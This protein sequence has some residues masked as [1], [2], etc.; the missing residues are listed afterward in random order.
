VVERLKVK[1][2]VKLWGFGKERWGRGPNLEKKEVGAYRGVDD[3]RH[4]LQLA[5][6][7]PPSSRWEGRK[8]E[9]KRS[10]GERVLRGKGGM[11]A[12]REYSQGKGVSYVRLQDRKDHRGCKESILGKKKKKRQK[13]GKGNNN[14][15]IKIQKRSLEILGKN[16]A[17]P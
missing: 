14:S 15:S 17:K 8:S 5:K 16:R 9:R 12:R 6:R 1:Y 3:V 10:I 4:P 11:S 13:A 7:E 2:R